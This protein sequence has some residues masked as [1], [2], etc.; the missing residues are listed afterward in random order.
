MQRDLVA[1]EGGE[2]TAERFLRPETVAQFV[3]QAVN[4]PSDADVHEIV[5]RPR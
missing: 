1:Y 4:A 5:L 2:Y 3:A